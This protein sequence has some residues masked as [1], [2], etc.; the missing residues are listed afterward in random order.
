[1]KEKKNKISG[2]KVHGLV[3]RQYCIHL[4]LRVLIILN[5]GDNMICILAC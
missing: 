3:G 2:G 1:M 5:N 4:Q